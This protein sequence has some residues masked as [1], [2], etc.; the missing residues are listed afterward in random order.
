MTA[1]NVTEIA[2]ARILL[3][4][5]D[6]CNLETLGGLLRPH[7]DVLAAPSGERALQIAAGV[8]KPDL[9]LLDV[10]M[11]GM[12]GYDVLTCLRDNPATRDIPV[13]FVTGLDSTED[14]EKGLEL[15]AVD[16][17]A[18][19]YHPPIVLARVRTQLELKRAR[20]FLAN[21]NRILEEQVEAR[22]AE[23]LKSEERY[24]RITEGLTDYLYT[25][26]IE[27]GRA[28]E[29]TQSPACA[30]VTGYAAEEFAANPHLWI[31]MV[32]PEDRE[33]VL[34]RVRQILEG[35]DVS[36]I[37][38][39][40]IQ[41]N[42]E[43]RWVND[44]IILFKDVSGKLLSY[45]GV[46]KDITERKRYQAQLERQA[47]F[48]DLTGLPNRNLLT[49]RLVQAIAR[50]RQDGKQLTVLMFKLDRFKEIADSLGRGIGDKLL[51]K[52]SGCLGTVGETA[53]TLAYLGGDEF[54]L[55]A[56]DGEIGE[57]VS[58][59][60]DIL[61]A[62]AQ[63]FLAEERELFLFA[64]IG[65]AMFP[66]DGED[67]ET[68]L[69]NAGAAMYRA[70]ASGG[71]NFLFYSA[72][73]NAHSL[74]RL[75]LENELRHAIE[76][77]EL[78]L[79]YQPQMSLRSG[80]L[81]GM[82]ALVRWQHPLRGLL[83]PME[84]IPLAEKTGLIVPL[85]EWVLRTACAQNR[86][87]QTEGLSAV[88]VAVNLSVRQFEGQDMVALTKQV[89]RETGLD[90][91]YLELELTESAAMDN[92]DAFVGITEALKGLSVTL[93]IDDFGTGY[94]S[95]SYLKRFALDR[96]KIDQSF[97]RDIVQDPGSAAIA[98][99]VIAL[100]HS[101]GLSVIAEG[102][103]TE[104][105]LNFLRVRG[106][107]EM[108]GFYFSRPLPATEFEQLL[109]ERRKLALPAVDEL[110]R[111]L[112]VDDEP[113]ILSAL[114]RLLRREGYSILAATSAQE[115][116]ELLANHEVAVVMS[117]QR[118]PHMTGSEFLAKV[119]VM[120]PDTIR[121]ILSGYTDLKAITDVVNRG[122]IYKF[123]EKPWED[124]AL[125]KILRE[126]FR[127]YETRQA[128]RVVAT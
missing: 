76:R 45:D 103:E 53:D 33:P 40:I 120:Y 109:R 66:Q 26:R 100:A 49:D 69:K 116:L 96:L 16:Y 3:V 121:I 92:A 86:A 77:D 75:N 52:I 38:H 34:E 44:T 99:A 36:S 88:A 104:A 62:L 57:T 72:E 89:L 79:Y 7:Y 90:P 47:N 41:K 19:P 113:Q 114:K 84:F 59:A 80:E 18:K 87:W 115:G 81:I 108:Q 50:C 1:D 65:I 117:D 12:D 2:R 58:I 28:V 73:M 119:R 64:S 48:D 8:P 21:H 55:L 23:L 91:S 10:L 37:E 106:C 35:N 56:K 68:L 101:L 105:Q 11:P 98:V 27:N 123:L 25:V 15:G 20:D 13:I 74:E 4:D 17:I 124:A 126:A 110:P 39:R 70:K 63:P 112:L 54:V 128:N 97:V 127:L 95:L 78:R 61:K 24:R 85:G 83:P 111:L 82:E 46:I 22:T 5:D 102:V 30:A 125:L 32:V 118:M 51:R 14:E 71:N 43:T 93:S 29:A 42:G 9:I 31:Q 122:E 60:H 67:G 94:S 107:D 6:P